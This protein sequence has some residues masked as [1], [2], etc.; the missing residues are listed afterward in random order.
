[1]HRRLKIVAATAIVLLSGTA[2]LLLTAPGRS[3]QF[4]VGGALIDLG[5]RLQDRLTSYDFANHAEQEL[6][7]DAIW[8]EMLRQNELAAGVRR[9]VPRTAH[10]PLV[11]LVACMDARIDTNELTGD[12]R[13][14]YYVIRTAGSV[15]ED[16]ELEILELAV[17]RGVKLIVLTTHSDCAA[18]GAAANPALRARYPALTR[19]IDQRDQRVA[20]LLARAKIAERLA[21]GALAVKL[22]DIDTGTEQLR[23]R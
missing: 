6:T 8:R 11:A 12:T 22:M 1:M 20:Q 14:F 16:K 9:R 7:P 4:V 19:A 17:E 3:V 2:V 15:L 21:N 18:E 5:Y 13:R 10:H 23:P